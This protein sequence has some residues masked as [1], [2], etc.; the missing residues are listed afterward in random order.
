[1]N[2]FDFITLA[3]FL[4]SVV[5]CT[6]KGFIKTLFKLGAFVIA[7]IVAKIF[8]DSIGELWFSDLIS[9][10]EN[11][12]GPAMLDKINESLATVIGTLIVFLIFYVVLRIIFSVVAKIVKKAVGITAADRILGA[13]FGV[14][15]A[16]GFMFVFCEALRI[17]AT[18][19]AYVNPDVSLFEI[20]EESVVFKYFF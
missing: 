18:V 12:I 2:I 19:I 3:V 6:W 4:V 20:V 9:S 13:V 10:S 16:F 1:M 5:V 17:A 14:V 11:A 7:A 8:G 15:L